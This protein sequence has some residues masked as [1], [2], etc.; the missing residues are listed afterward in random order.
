[1][2]ASPAARSLWSTPEGCDLQPRGLQLR[3]PRNLP[4]E[5]TQSYGT[6]LKLRRLAMN[7]K[8]RGADTQEEE[9][10]SAGK[11]YV[12]LTRMRCQVTLHP[13]VSLGDWR[14]MLSLKLITCNECGVVMM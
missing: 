6:P 8:C 12:W 5:Q 3:P 1:M 7:P 9:D 13:N 14:S 2:T 10:Q 4:S 11:C